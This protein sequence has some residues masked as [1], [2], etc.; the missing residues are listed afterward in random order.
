V[1]CEIEGEKRSFSM[2][3]LGTGASITRSGTVRPDGSF[4]VNRISPGRYNLAISATIDDKRY[5]AHTV[6]QVGGGDVNGVVIPV[7]AGGSVSGRLYVEDRPE[8]G[9]GG[10]TVGLQGW[11]TNG[12]IFGPQPVAKT[13]TDGS[14]QLDDVQQDHFGFYATG[15]PSG[16]YV[17]AVSAGGIDVLASGLETGSGFATLHV[18]VSPKAGIVEGSVQDARSQPFAGATVVLVPDDRTRTTYFQKAGTD[19]NGRFTFRTVVPG[20]YRVFAWEEVEAY[21]WRD[22]DFLHVVE[23]QSERVTV[24]EG[25]T[26]AVQLKLIPAH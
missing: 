13:K 3:L 24:A 1:N 4:E 16:Y 5:S 17:K 23:S 12:V 11:Q 22:P 2:M 20:G 8:E 10:I 18:V 26:Q 6:V 15:L 14:F 21:A 7:R 9:L 19:Q 25:S